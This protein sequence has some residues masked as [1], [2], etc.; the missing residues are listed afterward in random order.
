[1][2]NTI[3]DLVLNEI[4]GMLSFREEIEHALT[5]FITDEQRQQEIL[6]MVNSHRGS[7]LQELALAIVS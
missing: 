6:N 5:P 4:N 2:I 1:M 3:V 7:L